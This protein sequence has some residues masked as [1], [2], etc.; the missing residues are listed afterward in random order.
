MERKSGNTAVV[1]MDEVVAGLKHA[2]TTSTEEKALRMRYGATVDLKAPLPRA[3]GANQELEDELMLIEMHL[4]RALKH[5]KA[6][7]TK[8]AAPALA[9]P[10][11]AAKDKIVSKLK[12]K[13]K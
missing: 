12:A 1:T 2:N 10:R 7:A 3:A 6:M 11:N 8:A 5:R 9:S 4:L 13:K